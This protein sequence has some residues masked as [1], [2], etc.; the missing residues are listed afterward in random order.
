MKQIV[1]N[2]GSGKLA[3]VE[4]PVPAVG[5]GRV[6][7]RNHFSVVSPGTEKTA[8][9]F[10]RKSLLG[11]ARSRPDLVRQVL[12]KVQQ[13]GPL[14]T[15]RAVLNRLD[16]PQP[17]GYS[18]AGVVE[19]VG[20]GVAGFAPGDRVAC[21]GAGYANHAEWIAVPENLVAHAPDGL[22]LDKASFAT[23][24]AIA[25]QG[26]RVAQ[27]SL[28][29]VAVVIGLGLIGQ[30]AVQLLRANGCR[31]L[32]IDVDPA[33]IEQAKTQGAEWGARPGDDHSG[34]TAAATGG[35][36]AD[37]A[38]VTAASDSSA[39]IQ[40]AAELC[41]MKGR[42]AAVGATAMDLD[43]RTFYEKELDLR[44]SMSYG[45]GRYDRRY[46]E[47]GLD[48][49]IE[50]VRWTEN[51]N[52]Q[53]FLAL[54][55]SGAIDPARLDTQTVDFADAESAYE[56][57]A[58]GRRHGLAV[59][60]RYA[61]AGAPTTSVELAPR[62]A[63]PDGT[64]GVA[65]VG[66][67]NYAKAVLLP[68]LAKVSGVSARTIVTA[69][70]PSA[71]RS[72]EKFGFATCG[73][74][75]AA[76]IGDA[77]VDLVFIATQHDSHASLAEAALRAGKAVWLEK[78]AALDEASL[79]S[80]A[81]AARETGGFL[82]VG[83]NRR[84]SAHARAIRGAFASRGGPLAIQYTVAAGPTPGGTWLVDPAV[85]G[86]RIV[87]EACHMV[88]LC[89]Y[90][91]GAAPTSVFARALGRDPEADD[92]TLL[93]LGFADGSTATIAY[94][95]NASTDLPKERFEVSADGRTAYCE[96]FR[97]TTLPGGK[98]HK[99][100]NQDKGQAE[101]VR[102]AIESVRSGEP[103]P[104]ALD[105]LIATSR[106]TLRAAES[107]GSGRAVELGAPALA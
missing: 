101:A 63:K 12:R 48:Y 104:I 58:A 36:G 66:A 50:Y 71:R 25:L 61:A 105:E 87:G 83:Y 7:V 29:E 102:S 10:A 24:G 11:K 18:T 19:Q 80:L 54:A 107:I 85:G 81:R 84:F 27:P 77:S 52:L 40:L 47:S 65:F 90:L 31:V 26:I 57:L 95:A 51:R 6:L 32:G 23:L 41:R 70:G 30:L 78:P 3:L 62:A 43:R 91:V 106:A 38:L 60:F 5:P 28:G 4:V 67:G 46:E 103:S 14:P 72:A 97:E 86:G 35:H 100:L 22:A 49:P 82:T 98:R 34:W 68:A 93:V 20:A 8:I 88:D 76:A 89:G 17:L 39:P 9:D 74:D 15:V 45:P 1:Q 2:P 13:E 53:A 56:E 75:P 69:T 42:V 73:T 59:I 55:G 33:R 79:E 96:N 21:A 99:T 16:V 44:M 37:F 64:V 92:S 94:L